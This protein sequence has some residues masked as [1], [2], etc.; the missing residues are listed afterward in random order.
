LTHRYTLPSTERLKSKKSIDALFLNGQRHSVGT[1]RILHARS[2]EPG[3][4]VGVGV[5]SK[6]F[7][8]AVDRNRIKRQL[9]ECYRLQKNILSE[10]IAPTAGIDIFF[11]YTD[12][13]VPDYAQLFAQLQKGL[14]KLVTIYQAG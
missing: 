13:E 9:R 11:I 10:R 1:L 14:T 5:S 4:R 6:L 8:R 3:I 2:A 12:K 7:R